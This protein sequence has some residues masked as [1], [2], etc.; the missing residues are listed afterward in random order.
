MPDEPL[1]A[2]APAFRRAAAAVRWWGRATVVLWLFDAL[3][4]GPLLP[5]VLFLGFFIAFTETTESLLRRG[6]G[7]RRSLLL[8]A[9]ALT[10]VGYGLWFMA[11]SDLS[12]TEGRSLAVL[13]S[14]L[15][16]GAASAREAWAAFR[17][18]KPLP[19]PS[20]TIRVWRAHLCFAILIAVTGAA[21]ATVMVSAAIREDLPLSD[22]LKAGVAVVLIAAAAGVSTRAAAGGHAIL[23]LAVLLVPAYLGGIVVS[24]I[25]VLFALG[26]PAEGPVLLWL[27]VASVAGLVITAQATTVDAVRESERSR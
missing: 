27:L 15:I 7:S 3:L 10:L 17:H 25:A 14:V 26:T 20:R 1:P 16:L 21:L 6:R 4:G 19:E 13:A 23:L 5:G 18:R 8:H 12:A 2:P 24:L 9:A 22:R 11:E